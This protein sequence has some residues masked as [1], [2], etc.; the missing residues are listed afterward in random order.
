M[1]RQQ[2]KSRHPSRPATYETF[3]RVAERVNARRWYGTLMGHLRHSSK[4][5]STKGDRLPRQVQEIDSL[6]RGRKLRETIFTS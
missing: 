1:V 5:N 6:P 4:D 2:K 3:D